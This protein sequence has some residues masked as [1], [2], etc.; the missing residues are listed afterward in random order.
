MNLEFEDLKEPDL[1]RC[2]EIFTE[3][4]KNPPW[5]ESWT[6]DNSFQRLKN[7]LSNKN[8]IGIKVS[9]NKKIIGF[10]IGE[11]EQW[12]QHKSFYLKE[13]CITSEKQNSGIG[14]NL[15]C[16]LENRLKKID[17]LSIYLI[18]SHGSIPESF[19]KS[20]GFNSNNKLTIMNKS[21]NHG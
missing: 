19:Y 2:A 13:I 21:F 11:T 8:S 16:Y 6:F 18:T 4:F 1:K 5:N 17:I 14:K 3:T 12:I 9:Q 15:I 10:L 20:I 7:F